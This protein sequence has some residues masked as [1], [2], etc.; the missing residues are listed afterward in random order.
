[1]KSFALILTAALT[2]TAAQA[3][4][5]TC[6][7]RAIP[8]EVEKA[9]LTFEFSDDLRSATLSSNAGSTQIIGQGEICGQ[10][11]SA[12]CTTSDQSSSGVLKAVTECKQSD[13]R[14][15]IVFST[16]NQNGRAECKVG[17]TRMIFDF[18]ECN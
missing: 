4:A 2:A 13:S 16:V 3:N 7:A 15:M 9:R 18:F 17:R 14:A 1:M 8:Y 5:K 10:P 11:T 12:D 6:K